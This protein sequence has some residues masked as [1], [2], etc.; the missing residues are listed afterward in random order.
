MK[1]LIEEQIFEAKKVGLTDQ[2]IGE[3]F[4]VNLRYIEKVI[5]KRLGVNVSIPTLKKEI[6]MLQSKNFSIESTTVWSFKSRGN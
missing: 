5:T 4:N 3:R 1:N 2:K 6:K